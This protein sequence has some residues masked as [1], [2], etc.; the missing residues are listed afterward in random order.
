[1]CGATGT[2]VN[3]YMGFDSVTPFLEDPRCGVFVLCKT[4]NPSADQ[5]QRLRVG[6]GIVFDFFLAFL[7]FGG[8]VILILNCFEFLALSVSSRIVRTHS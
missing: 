6:G 2:T 3:P 4:S 5:I 1:M 8:G 7:F